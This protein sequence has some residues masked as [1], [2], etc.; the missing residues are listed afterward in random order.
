MELL[1]VLLKAIS[2]ALKP[3]ALMVVLKADVKAEKK[4]VHLDSLRVGLKV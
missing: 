2:L 1:T 3:V 4:G